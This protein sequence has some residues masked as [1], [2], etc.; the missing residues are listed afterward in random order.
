M[1]IKNY[2]Y[3]MFYLVLEMTVQMQIS[4]HLFYMAN[5]KVI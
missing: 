4:E 1:K 3:E 2:Q 5:H